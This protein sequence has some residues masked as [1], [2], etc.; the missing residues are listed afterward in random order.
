MRFLEPDAAAWLF[1][2]PAIWVAGFLHRWLRDRA[3]RHS[4]LGPEMSALAPLTG[5]RRDLTFIALASIAAVAL[6]FAAARPQ[7]PKRTPEYESL[8]LLLLLDRS[9]SMQAEDIRPSRFARANLEIRNFLKTRPDIIGR[10]GLI[11]F[12][13]ASL[14]LSHETRDQDIILFY[15]D[16]IEE[17]LEP[18]YGTNI[19]GAL[20][21][22]LELAAKDETDRRKF[23]VV[24]SDGEDH[25]GGLQQA[26][27]KFVTAKIPIY[28]IGIG[29]QAEVAIP[30]RQSGQRKP[31]LDES[32]NPLTTRFEE[33]TLRA[34]AEASGGRYFRS[35]TGQ[36]L[37]TALASITSRER[38]IVRWRTDEYEE[39][40]PWG[41]G[42][43]AV[44]LSWA[45][46]IL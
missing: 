3:R 22:A 8:D 18:L 16:W 12:A 29:S 38:R 27:E 35:T 44:A 28:T 2:I 9:A 33:A 25:D 10:V 5:M 40:Y 24:V 42:G 21:S 34:I 20:E 11:G 23:V 46:V 30:N 26:V 1:A 7:I 19:T 14:T 39:L 36:E 15:L 13:G 43:A 41:L 37:A 32:G 17:D 4:G 31:L 45:L 6:V